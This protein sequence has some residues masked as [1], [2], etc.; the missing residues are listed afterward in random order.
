MAYFK[1]LSEYV[2]FPDDRCGARNV[3]WLDASVSFETVIPSIEALDLLWTYCTISVMQ[4]RGFHK[5]RLCPQPYPDHVFARRNGVSLNLGSAEIR[6]FSPSGVA[7]AAPNLI[8][9]YV[10]THCYKPPDEFL[11]A[12]REGSSPAS[13]SYFGKLQS[14]R[15][16]WNRTLT[17]PAVPS[18]F[19]AERIDGEI[20]RVDVKLNIFHEIR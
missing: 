4:A 19:R 16:E 12:L 7:Y 18:A 10:N 13:D 5:C 8:Y 9:H 1:D 20:R 2:Y 11:T 6:V 17:P 14:F 3:G 15:L